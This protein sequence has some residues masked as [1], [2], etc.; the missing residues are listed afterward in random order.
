[1]PGL[2]GSAIK[3]VVTDGP[4]YKI[5]KKYGV[6]DTTFAAQELTRFDED[7]M[8]LQRMINKK[9]GHGFATVGLMTDMVKKL[10]N[11]VGDAWYDRCDSKGR[12]HQGC[13]ESRG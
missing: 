4:H 7:F 11:K 10:V 13:D 6:I 9:K 3:E 1:M 5:A 12:S 2:V 8:R